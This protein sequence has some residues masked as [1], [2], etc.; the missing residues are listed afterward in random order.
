MNNNSVSSIYTQKTNCLE[1]KDS[2]KPNKQDL[3][4]DEIELTKILCMHLENEKFDIN[5]TIMIIKILKDKRIVYSEI[6]NHLFTKASKSSSNSSDSVAVFLSNVYTLKEQVL[7]SD[8]PSFNEIRHIVL[9]IYDHTQLANH[10]VS[11]FKF[12]QDQFDT[13]LK[14][15]DYI[16]QKIDSVN[17]QVLSLVALFTAMA[18]LVFGGL[19]SFESIFSNIKNVSLVKIL[20]LASVWG[21]GIINVIAVFMFFTS[22]IIGKSFSITSNSDSNTDSIFH[23]YPYLVISNYILG[24]IFLLSCWLYL[25]LNKYNINLNAKWKNIS[26]LKAYTPTRV[27]I[28]V[29]FLIILLFLLY[30]YKKLFSTA[31]IQE[32][33]ESDS[34]APKKGKTNENCS[35]KASVISNNNKLQKKKPSKMKKK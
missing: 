30:M 28:I 31:Q 23:R 24:S 7:N 15:S 3:V 1:K 10:Q 16:N 2:L 6:S 8:D 17:S 13:Y 4:S 29:L 33:V 5:A 14:S 9:K 21:I 32:S 18:F 27:A 22:R 34:E 11:V 20:I 26:K 12:G 35:K 25:F 19:S